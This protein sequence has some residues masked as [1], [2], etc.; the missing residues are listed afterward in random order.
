MKKTQDLA[1]WITETP[2]DGW[3]ALARERSQHALEDFVASAIAGARTEVA[4]KLRETLAPTG[5]G[6]ASLVGGGGLRSSAAVAALINGAIGHTAEMDDNFFPGLGHCC[7][8]VHPALLALGE[9]E[10]MR[11]SDIH[12]AFIVGSEVMARLGSLLTRDHTDRG[13]HGTSTIGA[14][15]S[16]AAC[17]RL[18]HLSPEATATAISLALSMAA[19]PKA[20]FGYDAK[21]LHAGLAAQ[22][23]VQAS[24]LA[25]AGLTAN[26]EPLDDP[27]GYLALYGA[28]PDGGEALPTI[29]RELAIERWGLAFKR[30]P[31]CGSTHRILD[32]VMLL[33][34]E[35]PFAVNDVTHVLAEVEFGNVVN[36]RYPDAR[37]PKEAQFSMPYCVAVVLRRGQLSLADMTQQAVNDPETRRLMPLVEMRAL[38]T[39]SVLDP[40]KRPPH[41]VTVTLKDG[42]KLVREVR[43]PKGTGANPFSPADREQKFHACCDGILPNA[44]RDIVLKLLRADS[45]EISAGALMTA[46]RF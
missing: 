41:R 17:A 14:L 3:S 20:Q 43:H 13:W 26:P 19:G 8:V 4:R 29:G 16:A 31:S 12:D 15:A 21:P 18:L 44:G 10:G 23:G 2:F 7:V 30:H 6:K 39:P 1:L 40:D 22:A 36:L 32:A 28:G 42:R 38:S 11:L 5:S 34:V 27:N 24:V 37:T 45:A 46:L 25:A 33:Q 35:E 9:E